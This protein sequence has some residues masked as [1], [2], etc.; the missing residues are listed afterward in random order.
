[1]IYVLDTNIFIAALNGNATVLRRL[2]ALIP[3]DIV[4]CAPVLAELEY[5]ARFSA[6]ENVNLEKIKRL[7]SR[8]RFQVFGDSA[9]RRFGTLKAELR[10]RGTPK[11]D[12]DLS[13]ASIAFDLEAIL[14]SDDRAFHE[15]PIP[16]LEVE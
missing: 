16:G 3:E 7:S 13:I 1:M 10:R 11:S 15:D 5:G 2:D 8:T 4:L 14:V 12:F 6:R 9:A